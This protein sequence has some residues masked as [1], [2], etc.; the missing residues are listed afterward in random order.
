[1]NLE[2]PFRKSCFNESL[3]RLN[4]LDKQGFAAWVFT[5]GMLFKDPAIWWGSGGFRRR[6]HEGLDICFYRDGSGQNYR[7]TEKTMIPVIYDGKIVR[8]DDDFLGK[9]VYVRHGIYDDNG[10]RLYTVYGHTSPISGIRIGKELQE[11]EA[12]ARIADVGL[13]KTVIPPHLHLSV[14]WMPETFPYERLNWDL[15]GD[16]R[17]ITLCNPLKFINDS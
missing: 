17:I 6:L 7:L 12:F 15:M 8:I 2:V 10:N 3:I 13:R 9:S 14:A 1:M 5:P 11:G 16:A 4:G